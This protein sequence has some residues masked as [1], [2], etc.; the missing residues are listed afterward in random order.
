MWDREAGVGRAGNEWNE[1]WWVGR[2]KDWDYKG[3]VLAALS[4]T[5]FKPHP[6]PDA[7][8]W[9]HA[10]LHLLVQV[11]VD[12]LSWPARAYPADKEIL[13]QMFPC[14]KKASKT[15][16]SVWDEDPYCNCCSV[17]W[18]LIVDWTA[19]GVGI[20]WSTTSYFLISIYAII[21][22]LAIWCLPWSLVLYIC[23]TCVLPLNHSLPMTTCVI[24]SVCQLLI[25]IELLSH[26]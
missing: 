19:W 9:I 12:P 2:R 1:E 20:Y 26:K 5:K 18:G 23:K 15:E 24:C 6:R 16:T 8:T 22:L 17:M 25:Q 3:T 11:E 4:S 10:N 7:S 21:F 14:V 13:H